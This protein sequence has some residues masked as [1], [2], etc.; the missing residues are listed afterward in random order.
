LSSL[1]VTHII[2]FF[3][4]LNLFHEILTLLEMQKF[5][6]RKSSEKDSLSSEHVPSL[7]KRPP[8]ASRP[9]ANLGLRVVESTSTGDS[10][11]SVVILAIHGSGGDAESCWTDRETGWYWILDISYHDIQ[12]YTYGYD[13]TSKFSPAQH[14]DW[15][16]DAMIQQTVYRSSIIFLAKDFG[17]FILSEVR[18][19][20]SSQANGL[21]TVLTIKA[22]YNASM[23]SKPHHADILKAT[24]GILFF[25]TPHN[26]SQFFRAL[27]FASRF[28]PA[29]S[30]VHTPSR[31]HATCLGEG[32]NHEVIRFLG[33]PPMIHRIVNV[34]TNKA[35]L[36]TSR[37]VS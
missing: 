26:G 12:I 9:R 37:A 1:D 8:K 4:V 33:Q 27:S 2:R 31:V 7:S 32:S 24:I 5:F 10:E 35:E 6:G 34:H 17:G 16:L 30:R 13:S 15:L 23:D 18:S 25:N 14:A 22:L 21:R 20:G 3:I 28:T 36:F 29:I 11:A 19:T